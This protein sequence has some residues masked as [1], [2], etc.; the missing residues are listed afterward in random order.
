MKFLYWFFSGL[1]H[2]NPART[3]FYGNI[4]YV[5][6]ARDTGIYTGI[7]FGIITILV[8]YLSRKM[9]P[10][11]FPSLF[12]VIILGLFSIPI[13]LDT[14][15]SSIEV[16]QSSNEIRLLTGLYFGF[17][18][19]AF[20]SLAFFEIL[21]RF[22][23]FSLLKKVRFFEEWWT[24]AI[25]IV[26][27]MGLWVVILLLNYVFFFISAISVF[28]SIWF[29][30]FIFIIALIKKKTRRYALLALGTAIIAASAEMA[31]IAS[32]R[33]LLS[34]YLKFYTF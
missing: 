17:T 13:V 5:V 22:S 10:T 18:V 6:C 31:F 2:Q 30:N 32:I 14:G 23:R 33:W 15:L 29:G 9:A 28:I 4:H 34:P 16:W 27:P 7:V 19:S 8:I 11:V 1:C 26:I 24:V 3:L 20:L 25:F 12:T 21:T